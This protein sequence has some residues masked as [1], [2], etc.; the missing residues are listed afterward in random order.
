MDSRSCVKRTIEEVEALTG[1]PVPVSQ[2][3]SIKNMAV[4][5]IARGPVRLHRIRIHPNFSKEAE[6]LTC[7]ECGFILR[8][9]AVP[10]EKRCGGTWLWC[11]GKVTASTKRVCYG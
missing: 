7:F 6:Y 1:C 2:D 3:A 4:L 11:Q 5:D 10:P 8:K 9:F